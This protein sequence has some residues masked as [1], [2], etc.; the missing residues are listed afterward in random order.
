MLR[1]LPFQAEHVR[2][3]DLLDRDKWIL[4]SNNLARFAQMHELRGKGYTMGVAG[5]KI[6]A[7]GGI[8]LWWDH[9]G[10]AWMLLTP[11][12]VKYP[13]AVVRL[14][15]EFLGRLSEEMDLKRVQANIRV[16]DTVSFKFI[17]LMGFKREGTM[18]SFGT[19]GTDYYMYGR[20]L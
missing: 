1:L 13:V 20:V 7:C 12:A 6:I 11:Y 16:T 4:D 19:D 9:V 18:K 14:T 5:G 17:E 8:D 15:R 2:Y 3:M 10:E